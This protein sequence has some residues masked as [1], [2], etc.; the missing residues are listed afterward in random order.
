MLFDPMS[1]VIPS[2]PPPDQSDPFRLIKILMKGWWKVFLIWILLVPAIL[3]FF[4]Y[5]KPAFTSY[6]KISIAKTQKSETSSD[7]MGSV[8][9]ELWMASDVLTQ[10][11]VLKGGNLTKQT[12]IELGL[13]TVIEGDPQYLSRRP[14]YWEWLLSRRNADAYEQPFMVTESQ[15]KPR[16]YKSFYRKERSTP[17]VYTLHF[18]D[19]QSF[20]AISPRGGAVS[21]QLNNLVQTEE[22]SFRVSYYGNRQIQQGTKFRIT[23]NPAERV[24]ANIWNRF[25]ATSSSK[26][27]IAGIGSNL[28]EMSYQGDSP[29]ISHAFISTLLK[30]YMK[31]NQEFV[32]QSARSRLDFIQQQKEIFRTQGPQSVLELGQFQ[33]SE[34]AG[35]S[36]TEQKRSA[37]VFGSL[38]AFLL[39]EEQKA[40][41][42]MAGLSDGTRIINEPSLPLTESAP[43]FG[44]TVIGTVLFAFLFAC[45]VVV[46]PSLSVRW[47][48]SVDEVKASH[49]YPVFV[50][51]P[52]RPQAKKR[53]AAPELLEQNPQSRFG[54]SIRLLRT[55]LLHSMAGKKSQIVL[56]TSPMPGDGKSTVVC[57]LAT[58]LASSE[59]VEGV[60]LIDADMYRPSVHTV[61]GLHSAQG[62]SG[63]LNGSN[64]LKEVI[65]PVSLGGGKKM[66]V[67]CAGHVPPSPVELIATKAMQELLDYGRQHFTFVL[68]DSPPY[69][70][71]PT[72]AILAK[73]VDRVL[74]VVRVGYTDSRLFNQCVRDLE[75][76][77]QSLGMIIIDGE[78]SNKAYGYYGA[79]GYGKGAD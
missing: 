10:I 23:I 70:M 33:K 8:L 66:S 42:A 1:N 43:K 28:I 68:I 74:A 30:Q 11:D 72:S 75:P 12:I 14:R 5:K 13:N 46:I 60:L 49:A 45:A 37:E 26:K 39:L 44:V 52:H 24:L 55:N 29:Y 50:N 77:S 51:I 7:K 65:Q 67:V 57:N 41:I 27:G 35:S 59:Y 54:E 3:L 64:S 22:A 76:Q 18:D 17:V 38:S 78:E 40:K 61:F 20:R 71:S 58:V 31:Q 9:P 32:T 25:S 19:S 73:S 47:F 34:P 4:A 48:T 36:F 56:V 15:V 16:I 62:L 69:P 6:A 21:G 2:G 53:R 63:F 79:Y